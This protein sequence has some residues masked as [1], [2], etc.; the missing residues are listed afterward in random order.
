MGGLGKSTIQLVKSHNSA[1]SNR[2]SGYD[3]DGSSP[4]DLGL[5]SELPVVFSGFKFSLA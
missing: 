2:E 1:V 4:S 5:Y 3:E